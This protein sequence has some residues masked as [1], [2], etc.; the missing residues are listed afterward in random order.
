MGNEDFN[1]ASEVTKEQLDAFLVR[2]LGMREELNE[3]QFY[4]DNTVFNWV[5]SYVQQSLDLCLLGKDLDGTF[6]KK[7]EASR[8]LLVTG[9]FEMDRTFEETKP[10]EVSGADF[11][12]GNKL[13]LTLTVRIDAK[14]IDLSMITINGVPLA[15]ELVNKTIIINLHDGFQVDT[16]K[17]PVIAG[18]GLKM[19]FGNDVKNDESNKMLITLAEFL[20]NT[21]LTAEAIILN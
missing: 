7:E 8:E 11:A 15:P 19:Q 12:A 5:E 4:K 16:S 18:N 14:S 20:V 9:G 6:G 21:T 1:S 13:H 17:P 3:L 2:G 10:L